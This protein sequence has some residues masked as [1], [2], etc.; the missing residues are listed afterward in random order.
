MAA[1]VVFWSG[2]AAL[3]ISN[4][5]FLTG[6]WGYSVLKTGFAMT[7]GPALSVVF[8]GLSS[9]L[10]GRIGAARV[11]VIGARLFTTAAVW[12]AVV[13]E[14]DPSYLTAFLPA[15]LLA[16]AGIGL[17]V[18][19]LVAI[20]V[21]HLPP[22]RLA[23]AIAVYTVFRQVGAALGVAVWIAAVGAAPGQDAASY[24][25]GWVLI[26]TLGVAAIAILAITSRVM[27]QP[28]AVPDHT[29]V[30]QAEPQ[31]EPAGRGID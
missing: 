20:T 28:A 24:D 19:T 1:T 31:G 12:L 2:F 30:G 9:R 26:A 21:D 11:G 27:P 25:P 16:G 23:T 15:Q 14:S 4:A 7:P 5:L 18:P 10:A 29:P 6:V 22:A 8:A 17:L 13:P 3:L